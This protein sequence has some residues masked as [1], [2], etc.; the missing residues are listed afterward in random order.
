M[1]NEV[2]WKVVGKGTVELVFTSGKKVIL[3]NVLHVPDMRRNL[4]SGDLLGKPGIRVVFESGKLI[5][6]KNE[7]FV[8]KGYACNGMIKFSLNESNSSA[9]M[10]ESVTLWHSRLAH[11]GYSTLKFMSKNGL[12][13]YTDSQNDKCE[14]CIRSKF[15]KKPFPSVERS[16][17]ILDLIHTDICELNDILTLG[18][19]RY[20][21]TFIDH[22]S[23]YVYVHLLKNK[24]EAF[25]MFKIYK[26]EV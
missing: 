14:V 5:L 2:R 24:Y 21:I 13:P 8:G 25:I 1:G 6:L 26:V 18:G 10:I 17:Q 7:N 9:Y 15:T 19:R 16:S 4:V 22:C 11:I 23:R 12:I 3:T 20:F